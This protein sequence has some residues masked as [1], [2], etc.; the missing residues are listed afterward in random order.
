MSSIS[1]SSLIAESTPDS[2]VF[3]PVCLRLLLD[4]TEFDRETRFV[5]NALDTDIAH[6][7]MPIRFP[8]IDVATRVGS[9]SIST[10]EGAFGRLIN[11][12]S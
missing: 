1:S 5:R 9:C 6:S 7:G 2:E 4:F 11:V 3:D 8:V 12:S 10:D